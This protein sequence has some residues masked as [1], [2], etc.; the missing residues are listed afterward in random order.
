MHRSR[1]FALLAHADDRAGF[2]RNTL[3]FEVSRRVG[4][5]WTPEQ[6]PVE[7]IL[8][9][10]Y[11]GLYF[12]TETIRVASSRVN[13]DEQ[14][15]EE[16]DPDFI[17]G[18]WLVEIDNYDDEN[19]IR[20]RESSDRTLRITYHTPEKLSAQQ[21]DYLTSQ[22]ERIISTI[23]AQD[24]NSE[25]WEQLVD[26]DQ[27]ARFYLVQE[28]MD[29]QEAFHGSCFVYKDLGENE[30]WKFGPVWDFGNAHQRGSDRFIWQQPQFGNTLIDQIVQFP[31]FMERVK[32]HWTLFYNHSYPSISDYADDYAEYISAAA[33]SDGRRWP[34]YSN[35]DELSRER[36]FMQKL[37]A[38]VEWLYRQWGTITDIEGVRVEKGVMNNGLLPNTQH[39][40]FIYDLQGR[41]VSTSGTQHLSSGVYIVNGKKVII[42]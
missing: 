22:W 23:Y 30:Q 31:R 36:Q 27:L 41:K 16:T 35:A 14:I 10:E 6:Q 2:M 32:Y 39:P 15:D 24:K 37:S 5:P 29:N 34:Q 4:M 42:K 33:V 17:T 11:R 40:S 28:I 18:G 21:H 26:I 3:G 38:K 19:Q 12:L 1:H 20:L 13:I 9:G 7:L 8:N 25:S